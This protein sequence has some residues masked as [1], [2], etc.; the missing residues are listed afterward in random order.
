ME[1]IIGV[2]HSAKFNIKLAPYQYLHT[3]LQPKLES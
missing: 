3:P 2:A 1:N